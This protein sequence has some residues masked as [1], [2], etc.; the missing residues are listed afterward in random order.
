MNTFLPRGSNNVLGTTDAEMDR[1]GRRCDHCGKPWEWRTRGGTVALCTTCMGV[2]DTLRGP[3]EVNKFLAGPPKDPDRPMWPFA[4]DDEML[5]A[6]DLWHTSNR[7]DVAGLTLCEWL[8]VAPDVYRAWVAWPGLRALV[9]ERDHYHNLSRTLDESYQRS[10]SECNDWCAIVETIVEGLKEIPT[11]DVLT[12][13]EKTGGSWRC[14][15]VGV[16]AT[17]SL[18][19]TATGATV[20]DLAAKA[21]LGQVGPTRWWKLD[22][23]GLVTT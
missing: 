6:I 17:K 16:F 22:R 12:E 23:K 18:C 11:D 14:V 1:N 21:R 3:D 19:D 9:A 13:H 2:W 20:R 7:V 8:G 5:N 15:A 4:S 10:E